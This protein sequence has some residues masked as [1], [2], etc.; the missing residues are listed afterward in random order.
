MFQGK[1][2]WLMIY[3]MF[4]DDLRSLFTESVQVRDLR[5]RIAGKA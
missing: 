1:V 5:L 4:E 2:T 3:K